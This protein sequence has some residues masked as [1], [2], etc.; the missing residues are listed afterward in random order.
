MSEPTT[1]V[2]AHNAAHVTARKRVALVVPMIVI[3]VAS[4]D[5]PELV[6][7]EEAVRAAMRVEG[8]KS[9][10]NDLKVELDR[11]PAHWTET[12]ATWLVTSR[13]TRID[14]IVDAETGRVLLFGEESGGQL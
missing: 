2:A 1:V 5:G 9:L 7:R 3:A 6:S 13:S 12:S 11:S 8:V 14:A 10:P 4:C